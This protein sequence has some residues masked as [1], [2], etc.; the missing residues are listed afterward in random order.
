[1]KLTVRI[2]VGIAVFWVALTLWA[3]YS[4]GRHS[5]TDCGQAAQPQVLI[6]YN[7]DPIYNLDEQVCTAFAQGL[8][9][10]NVCA[11][12]STVKEAR[13]DE[14]SYAMY[15]LCANTYNWAPDWGIANFI[16]ED[17]R[18]AGAKTVAITLGAGFTDR[19][20]RVMEELLAERGAVVLASKAYWLMRPNDENRLDEPNVNVACDMASE[21]GK[22]LAAQLNH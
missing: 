15:V 9:A 17:E 8:S 7:P 19:S 22:E 10:Q 6:I 5:A 18:V 14:N 16:R 21:L 20:Q 2:A 11:K 3:Q 1:M 13:K 4:G 12:V